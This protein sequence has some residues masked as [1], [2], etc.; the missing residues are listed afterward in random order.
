MNGVRAPEEES[1]E[2]ER[3]YRVAEAGAEILPERSSRTG[4][5][6]REKHG[7]HEDQAAEAG[8][9][10]Q[11]A[12]NEREPDCQFAVGHEEG[13]TCGVREDKATENGRHERVSPT[14]EEFVDPELEAAMKGEGRAKDFVLAEDQEK[15]ANADAE[16]GESITIARAG[17]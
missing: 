8:G 10:H 2:A 12:K 9:T 15:D 16:Q 11:D 14:L 1:G 5:V 17:I 13:D 4:V 7:Q 6:R 3:K